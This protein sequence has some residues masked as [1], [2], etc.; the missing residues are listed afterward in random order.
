[1]TPKST[2]KRH[3]SEPAAPW[4]PDGC[5]RWLQTL[6]NLDFWLQN[7]DFRPFFGSKTEILDPFFVIFITVSGSFWTPRHGA[8]WCVVS[9]APNWVVPVYLLPVP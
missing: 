8:T 7:L 3:K 5:P 6:Q 9:D 4:A 2:Q 1:M